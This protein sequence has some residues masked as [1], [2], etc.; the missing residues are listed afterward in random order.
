MRRFRETRSRHHCRTEAFR[1][2]TA[3]LAGAWVRTEFAS[4]QLLEGDLALGKLL[5]DEAEFIVLHENLHVE[6][7][8]DHLLQRGQAR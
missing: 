8:F 7:V 5:L 2:R 4:P 6:L 1:H 3:G